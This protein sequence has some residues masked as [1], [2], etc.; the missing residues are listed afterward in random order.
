GSP[1]A[2]LTVMGDI[3][4]ANYQVSAD[5]LLEQAGYLELIGNLVSQVRLG[6]AVVGY[7]LR[8]TSAGVWTLFKEASTSSNTIQDTTLASGTASFSINNWHTLSL[9][10]KNGTIQALID[11]NR[12]A[13]VKD[14]T[15]THGQIGLLVS[16][17]IHARFDNISI[18]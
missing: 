1:T 3:N 10:L 11:N 7:H 16:K 18:V 12:V 6:G 8:I 17:W 15:Y 2:P 13:S 4:W 9:I 14:S 5:V